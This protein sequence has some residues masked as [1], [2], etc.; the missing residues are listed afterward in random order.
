MKYPYIQTLNYPEYPYI[1]VSYSSNK[2]N[3]VNQPLNINENET[4]VR[5]VENK[6]QKQVMTVKIIN[7]IQ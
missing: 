3:P 7:N 4:T 2:K 1:H 6:K 5:M